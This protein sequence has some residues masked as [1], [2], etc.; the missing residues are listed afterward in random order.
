MPLTPEKKR[1][2]MELARKYDDEAKELSRQ[3]YQKQKELAEKLKAGASEEEVAPLRG[4]IE[5]IKSRISDAVALRNSAFRMMRISDE[6]LWGEFLGDIRR[7]IEEPPRRGGESEEEIEER[8]R[9]A[10][11]LY[12][13]AERGLEEED[14]LLRGN[15]VREAIGAIR[16]CLR[17]ATIELDLEDFREVALER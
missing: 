4:E 17:K 11:R 3:L 10:R 2:L 15:P 16:S 9:F 5:G 1:A 7:V 13:T 6:E 14:I 12:E 8:R